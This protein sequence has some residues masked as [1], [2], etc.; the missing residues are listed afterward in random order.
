MKRLWKLQEILN[1]K[2]DY[3]GMSYEQIVSNVLINYKTECRE[4]H[5]LSSSYSGMREQRRE[6]EVV[7]LRQNFVAEPEVLFRPCLLD[8]RMTLVPVEPVNQEL[9]LRG[10]DGFIFVKICIDMISRLY[11]SK[12]FHTDGTS[13]SMFIY[14]QMPEEFKKTVFPYWLTNRWQDLFQG[15]AFYVNGNE[16]EKHKLFTIAGYDSEYDYVQSAGSRIRPLIHFDMPEEIIV[17]GSGKDDI[18]ELEISE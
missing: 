8:G 3:Y 6:K 10:K 12:K 16:I 18:L 13:M 4:I 15:G 9:W 2:I 5:N 14:H 1:G 11:G 17:I 7:H